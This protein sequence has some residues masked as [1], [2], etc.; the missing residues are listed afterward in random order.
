MGSHPRRTP[1]RTNTMNSKALW[2]VAAQQGD[3]G[4]QVHGFMNVLL[5]MGKG[6]K[7]VLACCLNQGIED[8]R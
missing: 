7:K 6:M 4:V 5:Q 1:R 2:G 3:L 8:R